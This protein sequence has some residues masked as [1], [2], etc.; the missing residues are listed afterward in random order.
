MELK[1]LNLALW[2]FFIAEV[3]FLSW[4]FFLVSVFPTFCLDAK[5]DQKDQGH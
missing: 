2:R 5:V 3:V 1:V 4:P